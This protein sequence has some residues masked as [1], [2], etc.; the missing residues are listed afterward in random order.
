MEEIGAAIDA[1]PD[2]NIKAVLAAIRR[3]AEDDISR[4]RQELG[5]WFDEMMERG[6]GVYKRW[7]QALSFAIALTLVAAVN[8]DTIQ[9]AKALWADESLRTS[10][11]ESASEFATEYDE[12]GDLTELADVRAELNPLPIGW[13]FTS[14]EWSEDWYRSPGGILL[15]IGGLLLSV[16]A[17]SLGAPFWFDLLS[18]FVRL[19]STGRRP[20]DQKPESA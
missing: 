14:A 13:D 8:A 1:L 12:T 4:Y 2:S 19:R 20:S 11:A 15:K 9:V 7:T 16:A 10:I 5:L 17:V 3:D 6:A 18:K